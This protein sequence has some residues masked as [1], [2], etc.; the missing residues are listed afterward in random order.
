MGVSETDAFVNRPTVLAR[1]P[2]ESS[3][4][5]SEA[6]P[7]N[8]PSPLLLPPCPAA[9]RIKQAVT[10]ATP[11]ISQVAPALGPTAPMEPIVPVQEE[12]LDMEMDVLVGRPTM[13]APRPPEASSPTLPMPPSPD[14]PFWL[15][16]CSAV[17]M[18]PPT[19][20]QRLAG[21]KIGP[22]VAGAIDNLT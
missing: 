16:P 4:P 15:P 8:S 1:R 13:I 10:S 14:P 3:S 19:S 21:G 12:E 2:P 17:R 6:A 11:L 7:P 9:W 20:M 22:A 5:T 18:D